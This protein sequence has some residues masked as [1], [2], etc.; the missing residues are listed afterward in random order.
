[1][2]LITRQLIINNNI[3]ISSIIAF[4]SIINVS[5]RGYDGLV[6]N[7]RKSLCKILWIVT[8]DRLWNGNQISWTLG[9]RA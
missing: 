3:Y 7:K 2:L 5:G 4:I 9:Y 1:M 6:K 8:I